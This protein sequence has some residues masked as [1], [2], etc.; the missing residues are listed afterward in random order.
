[1]NKN[2]RSKVICYSF[3]WL[4]AVHLIYD[5]RTV[6]VAK[7]QSQATVRLSSTYHKTSLKSQP[8]KVKPARVS[9]AELQ[10][11]RIESAKS[12]TRG[13]FLDEKNGWVAGKKLLFRTS[14]GGRSWQKLSIKVTSEASI[15]SVFFINNK[16]G[17]V[18]IVKEFDVE[19]FGQQYS[20]SL[21]LTSDGGNTW[22]QKAD[23]PDGVEISCLK[24]LNEGEGIATGNRMVRGTEGSPS[25]P[26]MFVISTKDGG[27]K[28]TDISH[29]VNAA[30]SDE[31]GKANDFGAD[32]S[33]ESPGRLLLLTPLGRIVSSSDDGDTW[34]TLT[35]LKSGY[36][37]HSSYRKIHVSEGGAIRV[38]GGLTGDEGAWGDLI[39]ES[40]ENTWR[41]Y[42]LLRIPILDAISI[43]EDEIIV[44]GGEAS[45]AGKNGI[46]N[47]LG[48]FFGIILRSSDAGKTWS[49]IYKSAVN[50]SFFSLTKVDEY[51]Y[52]A[53]SDAGTLVRFT[54]DH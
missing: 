19:P 1:M 20:S 2:Y 25:Y 50:E 14:D 49:V 10:V 7:Q 17:W 52:Y 12:L 37:Y 44:C 42:E 36:G 51:R 9:L 30:I 5:V 35:Q 47:R 53:L 34:Q 18:S 3:L 40:D 48:P 31:Y 33:W 22:T 41:S 45:V 38:V 8:A 27:D 4:T 11:A 16:L 21:L 15:S 46:R 13:H 23:Y 39:L 32:V 54:L 28:W 6:G 29:K 43:S 26:E 24:F